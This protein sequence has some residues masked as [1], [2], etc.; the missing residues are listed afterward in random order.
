M[1]VAKPVNANT[2][3]SVDLI[4]VVP[5]LKKFPVPSIINY[6]LITGHYPGITIIKNHAGSVGILGTA[7]IPV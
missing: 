6:R 2:F 1:E 3:K 7:E 5:I 4:V